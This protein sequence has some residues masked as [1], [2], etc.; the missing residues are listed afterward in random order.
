VLISGLS[1]RF[2]TYYKIKDACQLTLVVPLRDSLC[3]PTDFNHR[4]D[5][6]LIADHA[7]G[8]HEFS[9]LRY[10]T[11]ILV[12]DVENQAIRVRAANSGLKP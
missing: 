12:R 4:N 9:A 8:D 2:K 10:L 6:F 3:I 5:T 7:S 11:E 1:R